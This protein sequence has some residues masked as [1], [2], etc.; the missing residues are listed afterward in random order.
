MENLTSR[1]LHN[2]TVPFRFLSKIPLSL[3]VQ[4]K[5]YRIVMADSV[6]ESLPAANQVEI[7]IEKQ[8]PAGTELFNAHRIWSQAGFLKRE[9]PNKFPRQPDQQLCPPDIFHV[10]IDCI[11]EK[12]PGMGSFFGFTGYYLSVLVSL[13]SESI[14][15]VRG[16]KAT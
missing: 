9:T 15:D 13:A 5:I 14:W 16:Q 7:L 1:S 2:R 8:I 4:D 6:I 3:K 10:S 12:N 11:E